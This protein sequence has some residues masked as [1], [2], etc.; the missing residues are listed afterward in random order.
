M[1]QSGQ[2]W[3][4]AVSG[5]SDSTA[6]LEALAELAGRIGIRL[7]VA[8]FN[9][10]L[11]GAESDADEA[12]VRERT[13]ALGLLFERD[14]AIPGES[15]GEN[16]EATARRA[17]YAFFARLL[18]QGTFDRIATGHTQSDQAETVLFRVLRGTGVAGLAGV[19]PVRQPGIVRPLIDVSRGEVIEWLQQRGSTW[20]EDSSNS[21]LRFSR[22]RL[23]RD[24]LPR[25]RSEWN[26]RVEQALARLGNQAA[27]E[28][29]YWE[30]VVDQSLEA[31]VRFR[32]S[33]S[34]EIDCAAARALH[35]AVLNR[36]LERLAR[37]CKSAGR[38]LDSQALD[39][40]SA[41]IHPSGPK[42]GRLPG[43]FAQR[44]CDI[45][46]L[47]QKSPEEPAA[48]VEASAP[49]DIAAPDG[50]SRVLLQFAG[51]GAPASQTLL[52]YNRLPSL[53]LR[54]WQ[55]GDR[56]AGEAQRPLGELLRDSRVPS[57]ERQLWPV[58]AGISGLDAVVVWSRGFGASK[59][60]AVGE[61]TSVAVE[62]KEIAVDG[63]EIR[64]I[65]DWTNGRRD[66]RFMT[67]STTVGL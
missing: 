62:V 35:P 37:Q 6:L 49:S 58:L 57:W 48:P 43:L 38:Q 61:A 39:Q 10:R 5:G 8:H 24:L 11:R 56:L 9:H 1:A 3:G 52:D 14:E 22:N 18:Q 12:F 17:R 29:G 31:I 13:A 41:M 30:R 28:E 26:P 45:L 36:C 44:S 19:R 53:H 20:R 67:G 66:R 55:P 33:N 23:R 63:R 16:L 32:D 27:A 40:L 51:G 54:A 42:Q 64:R 47:G 25:L 7:G 15:D 34:V 60:F 59:A 50:R 4:V 2:H 21:N 46:L 65:E